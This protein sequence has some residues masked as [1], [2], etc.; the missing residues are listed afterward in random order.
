MTQIG[1]EIIH[2]IYSNLLES[3]LRMSHT[4]TYTNTHVHVHV[5]V[6]VHTHTHTHTHTKCQALVKEVIPTQLSS[7]CAVVAQRTVLANSSWGK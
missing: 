5:H 1:H 4:Y 6:H 3:K 2:S 7:A